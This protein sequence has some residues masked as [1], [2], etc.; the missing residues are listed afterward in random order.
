MESQPLEVR[1]WKLVN[2]RRKNQCWN[3]LGAKTGQGYGYMRTEPY[4]WHQN[5][6][7]ISYRLHFG[8]IPKGKFVFRT[9][10]NKLCVNP[11]HLK[12]DIP[13]GMAKIT[14]EQAKEIRRLHKEGKRVMELCKQYKIGDTAIYNII[15]NLRWKE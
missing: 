15:N 5:V 6:H 2:K 13:R 11:N 4:T 12:L 7:V 8:E 9:C 3:W 14:M 1:F 10:K